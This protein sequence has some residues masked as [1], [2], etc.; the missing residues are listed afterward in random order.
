MFFLSG[1]IYF[2]V[3]SSPKYEL[4]KEEDGGESGGGGERASSS[5]SSSAANQGKKARTPMI[6]HKC[7]SV[8]H[9]AATVRR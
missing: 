4:P 3:I 6:C 7:G 8:G 5:S 1:F 9:K 2:F